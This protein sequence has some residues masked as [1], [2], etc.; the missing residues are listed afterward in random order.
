MP[1]PLWLELIRLEENQAHYDRAVK[2]YE[3]LAGAFP[4]EQLSVLALLSPGRICLIN[5]SRPEESLKF[6][7]AA[8]AS[9]V[10]HA[11][12]ETNIRAGIQAT[13]QACAVITRAR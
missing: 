4:E 9:S 2:E 1:A 11:K 3:R 5:L 6:Y 8:A 12:R 13:R 7:H 10:P